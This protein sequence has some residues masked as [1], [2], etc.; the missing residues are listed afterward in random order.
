MLAIEVKNVISVNKIAIHIIYD[1]I[2]KVYRACRHLHRLRPL[3]FIHRNFYQDTKQLLPGRV[4][5]LIECETM[6]AG[7]V[8]PDSSPCDFTRDRFGTGMRR[9]VRQRLIKRALARYFI[10]FC[11]HKYKR[12]RKIKSYSC[13][14]GG[15]QLLF[16]TFDAILLRVIIEI[17][18]ILKSLTK[19]IKY[20][21]CNLIKKKYKIITVSHAV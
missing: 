13:F 17:G 8:L 11:G 4:E 15:C 7:R 10:T 9:G 1:S 16:L 6:Y 12:L 20:N 14:I 2:S 19:I 18:L 5:M 3:C 21:F